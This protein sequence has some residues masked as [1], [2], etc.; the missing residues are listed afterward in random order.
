MVLLLMRL[1]KMKLGR[2]TPPPS[3]PVATLLITAQRVSVDVPEA[4]M[5]QPA[6]WLPFPVRVV[7]SDESVP[8]RVPTAPPPETAEFPSSTQ[9]RMVR[10]SS[11]LKTAP[12]T[13]VDPA[14][15]TF[16]PV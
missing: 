1:L 14:P 13:S 16:P 15:V 2:E 4:R 12:P 7:D 9:S 6:P 11:L 8:P 10:F 3:R 5:P